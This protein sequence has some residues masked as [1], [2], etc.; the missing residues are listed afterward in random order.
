MPSPADHTVTAATASPCSSRAS[1][2]RALT[3]GAPA[4]I[5]CQRSSL[6]VEP[7]NDARRAAA[8]SCACSG[9]ITS[10]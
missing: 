2:H 7:S 9:P 8:H 1:R 10:T 3:Y 4:A 6:N 5:A